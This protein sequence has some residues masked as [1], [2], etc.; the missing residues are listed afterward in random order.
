MIILLAGIIIISIGLWL[1]ERRQPRRHVITE[2]RVMNG[3]L[4][5][6]K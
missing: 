5:R 6:V 3:K 4:V 1:L 2:Y